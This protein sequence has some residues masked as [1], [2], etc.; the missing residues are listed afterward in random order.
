MQ[1]EQKKL[2][3]I[4]VNKLSNELELTKQDYRNEMNK[5]FE[6]ETQCNTLKRLENRS[7]CIYRL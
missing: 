3:D 7:I 2:M 1:L 4:E 5:V 6:L